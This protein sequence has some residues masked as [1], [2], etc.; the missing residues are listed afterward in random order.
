MDDASPFPPLYK[1]E[2]KGFHEFC[3]LVL[4]MSLEAR[5]CAVVIGL[6]AAVSFSCP[7]HPVD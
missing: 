5:V 7:I 2:A 4:G 6:T 3:H 1:N